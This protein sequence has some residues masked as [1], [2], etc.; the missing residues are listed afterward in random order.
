MSDITHWK[1]LFPGHSFQKIIWFYIIVS[2]EGCSKTYLKMTWISRFV[3][4]SLYSFPELFLND[5]V[6]LKSPKLAQSYQKRQQTASSLVFLTFFRWFWIS[7]KVLAVWKKN[8]FQLNIS[9]IK[10]KCFGL[11]FPGC[12]WEINVAFPDAMP[13]SRLP[14]LN[15]LYQKYL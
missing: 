9:D 11:I 7:L 6:R 15:Y 3:Q 13:L 10:Y 4:V 2:E 5:C 12:I 14:D 1:K 8:I